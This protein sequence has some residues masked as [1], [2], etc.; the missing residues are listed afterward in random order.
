[1]ACDWRHASSRDLA[2]L[3]IASFSSAMRYVST[4]EISPRRKL[5]S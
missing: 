1:L 4:A 5:F 2:G 3:S